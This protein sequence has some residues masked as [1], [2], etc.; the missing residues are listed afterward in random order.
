[1]KVWQTAGAAL[2]IAF[3]G[4]GIVSADDISAD[5]LTYDGQKKIASAKGNVVIHVNE[6]AVMTGD[7]GEYHFEDRSAFLT[8]NVRYERGERTMTADMVHASEDKTLTGTGHVSMYDGE[9]ERTI[10]GDIV[11]YNPD[12]GYSKVEGNGFISTPDGSLTA[13]LIE[14]SAKEIRLTASGG[15]QFESDAH[16]LTGSGDQAVYTKSPDAD[17]GK[18]V[19]TGHAEANQNGNAFYGPELIFTLSD[20]SVKT[21]GR[22]TLVITNTSGT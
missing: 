10:K 20:N 17:D 15:V 22:S 13:P 9:E 6:G 1:M 19:L 18:V 21:N 16:Q 2:L 12:T 5:V 3:A 4:A 8:G 14:G 7:H 11:T